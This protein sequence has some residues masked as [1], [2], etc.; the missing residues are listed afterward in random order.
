MISPESYHSKAE[1][2]KIAHNLKLVDNLTILY[3]TWHAILTNQNYKMVLLHLLH[4][5]R[6]SFPDI[7][8]CHSAWFKIYF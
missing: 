8:F 3:S 6:L 7:F 1:L 2:C 4:L 5:H